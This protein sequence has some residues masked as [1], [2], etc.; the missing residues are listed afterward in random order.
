MLFLQVLA[1]R[2]H[3][4]SG[5][6]Q[7]TAHSAEPISESVIITNPIHPLYGQSVQVLSIRRWGSSTRVIIS[8]PEGGTLSLPA[9]ETSWEITSSPR[10]LKEHKPLF[11]P[12][13]LLHLS[14]WVE[15][16]STLTPKKASNCQQPEKV[17]NQ[18]I[19][20]ETVQTPG[21]TPTRIKRAPKTI[22]Q[23]NSTIGCQNARPT[24]TAQATEGRSS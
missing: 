13:K 17:D 22:N 9:A 19:D 23:S 15:K 20:D 16:L 12:N 6:Y 10:V 18:K 1:V 14:Q 8:H 11:D 21:N 2:G 3:I 5:R 7:Q 4:L 24:S